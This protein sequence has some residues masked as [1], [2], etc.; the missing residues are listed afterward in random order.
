MYLAAFCHY[1]KILEAEQDYKE[2]MFSSQFLRLS[3]NSMVQALA[4]AS[5]R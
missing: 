1:N 2:N 5:G 4:R 3:L